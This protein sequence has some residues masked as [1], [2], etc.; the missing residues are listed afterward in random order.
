MRPFP[1]RAALI[2]MMLALAACSPSQPPPQRD[3]PTPRADAEA[4]VNA[5]LGS[6]QWYAW[7]DQTLA[8]SEDGHGPDRGSP[9]W[10]QAVQRRLGQE[11]PQL[12]PGT[13]S[14]QQAVDALLR[15]RTTAP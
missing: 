4:S 13:P 5:P 3:A 8:I 9:E 12:E 10:N 2:P 11:A 7:V 6:T 1:L 15:T 14:W